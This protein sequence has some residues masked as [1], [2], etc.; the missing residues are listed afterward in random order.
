LEIAGTT[1]DG[2]TGPAVELGEEASQALALAVHELVTNSI[3]YGAL[4]GQGALSVDWRQDGG[5]IELAWIES[6]LAAT[7]CIDGESFGTRFIRSLI[8]RQLKGAW[9]RRAEADRL[10]ITIRWPAPDAAAD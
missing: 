4:S 9:V 3:K 10:S 5:D 7:P 1:A 8:E 6:D 2:L